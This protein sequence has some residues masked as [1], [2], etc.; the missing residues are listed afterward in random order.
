[1]TNRLR[2]AASNGTAFGAWCTVP[3]GAVT[4][5]LALTDLDYVCIDCQ[6]GLVDYRDMLVMLQSMARTNVTTVVRVVSHDHATIGKVLDAGADAVIVPMVNDRTQAEYVASACRYAP[7]GIRS[8]GPVRA[9]ATVGSAETDVLDAHVLCLVMIET[10]QGVAN[11]DEICSTPG[12]DGIYIGPADLAISLGERPGGLIPGRHLESVEHVLDRCNAHGIIPAIHSYD[13]AT[14]RRYAAMG[15][16]MVT[17]GVDLRLL[18]AAVAN[19]L[20]DAR[21]T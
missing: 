9:A 6:H 17:V 16:R 12:I 7:R 19:E 18:R 14:A 1:L 5:Q 10:E 21:G 20:R 3:S 13:G 4:E 15:F 2:E 8:Y 11:A